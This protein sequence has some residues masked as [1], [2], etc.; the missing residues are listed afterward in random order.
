[1][2]KKQSVCFSFLR[3]NEIIPKKKNE[4]E[5]KKKKKIKNEGLWEKNEKGETKRE[6]N[7]I[8]NGGKGFKN[9]SF[10][11]VN[12]KISRGG[13]PTPFQP[14]CRRRVGR[15]FVPPPQTYS[16]GE[17]MNLKNRDEDP[18]LAKNRIRVSVPQTKRDFKQSI[19]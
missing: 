10:R 9:A 3:K 6:E 13:L 12:C 15:G 11:V 14:P 2:N 19:E 7:Y 8:K 17:K 5:K 16:S 18:V 4:D 1:M